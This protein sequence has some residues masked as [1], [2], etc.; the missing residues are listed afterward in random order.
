MSE[1]SKPEYREN[2]DPQQKHRLTMRIDN[3][4]GQFDWIHGTMQFNVEN[5]ECLPPPKE[6]PGGHTSPVPVRM[7]PFELE[8]QPDGEYTAA[9]FTDGMIDEDYY[10]RGVCRWKLLN[11]QVQ[12][13]ATGAEEETLFMA[14]L[15][16]DELMA[17]QAKT[18][19]YWKNR[20]PREDGF[21]SFPASG[22]GDLSQVPADKQE[23]F[24]SISL[25]AK[26]ATP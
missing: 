19:Y 15:F 8:R 2:P 22:Q 10:D 25:T 12:L 18:L 14:D 13:K 11:V 9:V 6:N 20:Y 21:D 7:I 5:T 16:Q 24:F 3:A 1:N 23:E 17:G 4:P 26:E